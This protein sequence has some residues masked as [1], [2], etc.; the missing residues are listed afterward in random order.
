MKGTGSASRTGA[1]PPSF[2]S[3]PDRIIMPADICTEEEIHQMVHSFYARIREDEVL[4]PI[5]NDHIDDWPAHLVKLED[6][7]SSLLRR[8]G[9]FMGQPMPK[10]VALPHLTAEMFER[11]LALFADNLKD[12]PNQRMAAQANAMAGRIAQR[13]WLGYQMGNFPDRKATPLP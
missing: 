4:G 8:T 12:N 9:R 1:P 2:P 3:A 11:W 5:F 6:F 7:W 10:H 13:L